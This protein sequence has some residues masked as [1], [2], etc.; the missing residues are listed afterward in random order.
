MKVMAL[1][2]HSEKTKLNGI[3][4]AVRVAVS[5]DMNVLSVKGSQKTVI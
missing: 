1:R 4:A 3:K 2:K 5:L